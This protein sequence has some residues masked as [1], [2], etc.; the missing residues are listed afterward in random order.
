MRKIWL[1]EEYLASISS[2][3]NLH[4]VEFLISVLR[5]LDDA[6][7]E[8]GE[9]DRFRGVLNVLAMLPDSSC[10]E[11]RFF[12]LFGKEDLERAKVSLG[13][14]IALIERSVLGDAVRSRGLGNLPLCRVKLS[15][16]AR[17]KAG[18]YLNAKVALGNCLWLLGSREEAVA[19]LW[20]VLELDPDDV[21]RV[22]FSLACWLFELGEDRALRRLIRMCFRVTAEVGATAYNELEH[23]TFFYY[24]ESL[25]TFR[26]YGVKGN[27]LGKFKMALFEAF[28]NNLRVVD[29]LLGRESL[30]EACPCN[31]FRPS[32]HLE[33][34]HC[35]QHSLRLWQ[36]VPG[37]LECLEG[38]IA[39]RKEGLKRIAAD[40]QRRLK[41][42]GRIKRD[43]KN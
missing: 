15:E 3:P 5:Q 2:F 37:A 34:V 26:R 20:D 24:L 1:T 19:C 18:P 6:V 4:K 12:A 10:C 41:K 11:N 33:A 30:P 35:V 22:R 8:E 27:G 9:R 36:S 40:H 25:M 31:A 23:F 7:Q 17:R 13:S 39:D 38:V 32:A 16:A 28:E 42:E 21:R 43:G 29:F 14:A